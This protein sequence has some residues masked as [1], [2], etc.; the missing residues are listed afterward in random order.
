ML[1]TEAIK[2]M[3]S[4]CKT[5]KLMLNLKIKKSHLKFEG[6]KNISSIVWWI[7]CWN[8]PFNNKYASWKN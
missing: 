7:F 8:N 4:N 1:D 5:K 2:Q 6:L 3:F